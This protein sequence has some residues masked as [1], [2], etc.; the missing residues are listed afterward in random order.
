LVVE[1]VL[2]VGVFINEPGYAVSKFDAG[3]R[4][5]GFAQYKPRL[6]IRICY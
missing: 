4:L 3:D 2:A 1:D 5:R 6:R